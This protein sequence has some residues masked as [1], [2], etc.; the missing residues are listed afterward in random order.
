MVVGRRWGSKGLMLVATPV[1][2]L[3]EVKIIT[4]RRLFY[5]QPV[6]RHGWNAPLTLIRPFQLP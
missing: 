6:A 3:I 2:L 5:P 1:K 4:E